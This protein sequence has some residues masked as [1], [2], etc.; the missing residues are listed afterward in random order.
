MNIKM[1]PYKHET[2]EGLV[3]HSMLEGVRMNT[4][5]GKNIKDE[6][7]FPNHRQIIQNILASDE[8]VSVVCCNE[9]D[10]DQIFGYLIGERENIVHFVYV[11]KTF[12]GF[13]F[14][15]KMLEASGFDLHDLTFTHWTFPMNKIISK[16]DQ[17]RYNPYLALRKGIK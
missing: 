7:L 16:F 14:S 3:M 8:L 13:G 15:K 11:K 12:R 9:D 17:I 5:F 10:E 6:D 4:W 1:R 2:D